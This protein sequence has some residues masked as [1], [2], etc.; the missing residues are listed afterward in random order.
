MNDTSMEQ[1]C[2]SPDGKSLAYKLQEWQRD[3]KGKKFIG[4]G[5]DSKDRIAIM[6]DEG[7]NSRTLNLPAATWLSAPDWR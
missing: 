1:C 4:G 5:A 2:W 6:D 7:K 3:E